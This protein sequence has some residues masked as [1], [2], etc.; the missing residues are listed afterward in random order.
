MSESTYGVPLG[1]ALA[2]ADFTAA[3]ALFEEIKDRF[4]LAR[5]WGAYGTALAES[6][7]KIA[8]RAYLKQAQN[9]FET[10][11]ANGELQRLAPAV[12]RSV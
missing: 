3:V 1:V 10:I 9:T 6:G 8:A 4:E 5:T 11:G 7:D 2:A 12:E